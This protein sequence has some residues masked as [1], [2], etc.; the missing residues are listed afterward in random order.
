MPDHNGHL[1]DKLRLFKSPVVSPGSGDEHH[2]PAHPPEENCESRDGGHHDDD[3]PQF[4]RHT[5]PTLLELFFDLLFAAN[6]NVFSDNHDVTSSARVKACVGY[7]CLLWLTWL[8]VTLYDVRFVTDSIFTR[9]TRVIH[10]GVLVVFAMV[11]PKF[12]ATEHNIVTMRSMSVILAVSRACLAVDYTTT[13]WHV[14]KFKK[15]RLPLYLQTAVH[16]AAAA[17]YLGITFRLQCPEGWIFMTWYFI[18]GA[19]AIL[20]MLLSN[21]SPVLSL[22]KTHLIKRTALLTVMMLGDS[23]VHIAKEVV[24]IVKVTI[25]ETPDSWSTQPDAWNLETVGHV[26]AAVATIYFIF[27]IYF[28]WL[29]SSFYLPT[30]R[31]QLWTSLHLPFHLSLV[32]FMQGFTQFLIFSKV[33]DVQKSVV[34]N[35]DNA[36]N[37]LLANATSKEVQDRFKQTVEAFFKHYSPTSVPLGTLDTVNDAIANFTKIPDSFWPAFVNA[38]ETNNESIVTDDDS[39]GWEIFTNAVRAVMSSLT[40]ALY[41]AFGVNLEDITSQNPAA[42]KDIHGREIPLEIM[43]LTWARYRLVFAY[44]YVASGCALIFMIML[45]LVART[46]PLKSWP[47]I[48]LVIIFLLAL[49]MSLTALLW[50]DINRCNEFLRTPWV[51]PT[52]TLVWTIVLVI[53]HINREGIKRITHFFKRR[54]LPYAPASLPLTSTGNWASNN[55]NVA[56]GPGDVD[57]EAQRRGPSPHAPDDDTGAG[58]FEGQRTEEMEV[59]RGDWASIDRASIDWNAAG[60]PGDVDAEAQCR[61][62]SPHAS[63]DDTGAGRFEG[64]RSDE[65]GVAYGGSDRPRSSCDPLQAPTEYTGASHV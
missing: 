27:L 16:V 54:R 11:A 31:Q 44:S 7:F 41:T 53:T 19:E 20:T 43:K 48:R 1:P 60:G 24:T 36:L 21:F 23:I 65:I 15:A 59:A 38:F 33:V 37:P 40:N 34:V 22:T 64:Q 39:K 14:R 57:S 25:A 51:L 62:L 9:M 2:S 46:T 5:E 45:T 56:R 28:D 61:A 52:I 29:R 13:L 12:D 32:L 58:R 6:Y 3:L 42:S 18:S 30:W 49:G 47:I 50:F 63:D 10:L 8:L 4:A 17:I 26:M 35:L 55:R